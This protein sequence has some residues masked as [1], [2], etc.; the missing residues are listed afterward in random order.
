MFHPKKTLKIIY[1]AKV[2]VITNLLW[3]S[4]KCNF[5]LVLKYKNSFFFLLSNQEL[6]LLFSEQEFLLF[7]FTK[8]FAHVETPDL[9]V[10]IIITLLVNMVIN[11]VVNSLTYFDIR[12]TLILVYYDKIEKQN[13]I[14]Q[15]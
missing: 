3:L 1:I 4:Q 13:L 6:F 15:M 7:L 8:L 9:L 2:P 12:F 14:H 11:F 10:R 5:F